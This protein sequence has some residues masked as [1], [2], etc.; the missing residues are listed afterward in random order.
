MKGVKIYDM[1]SSK[2]ITFIGRLADSPRADL[3][4]C[5]LCWRTDSI[6]LIGWA[7][8][9]KVAVVKSRLS[10]QALGLPPLY[11]EIISV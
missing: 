2:Q 3:Y 11:V 10:H 4:K 6:L 8:Y 5:R 1:S 7:D 9:V